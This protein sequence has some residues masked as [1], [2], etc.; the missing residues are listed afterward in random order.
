MGSRPTTPS[1]GD[2]PMR[3]TRRR[4]SRRR[5][6]CKGGAGDGAPAYSSVSEKLEALKQL[7]PALNGERKAEQLFQETADYIVLLR[8]QVSILQKLID[9]YAA[10]TNPHRQNDV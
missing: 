6:P 8:T 9:I 2:L 7:I 3:K 10:D 4:S 5:T 1:S